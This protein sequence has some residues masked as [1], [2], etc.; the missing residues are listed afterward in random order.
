[1]Y[2]NIDIYV[3]RSFEICLSVLSAC[4]GAST[5]VANRSNLREMYE[6]VLAPAVRSMP[7]RALCDELLSVNIA[8][9]EH[10]RVPLIF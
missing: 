2:V 5:Y 4:N 6:A 3:H 9:D 8:A 10:H 7:S 1:M